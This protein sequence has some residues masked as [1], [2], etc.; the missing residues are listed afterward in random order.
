MTREFY[1]A[2]RIGRPKRHHP[3]FL[4]DHD[5]GRGVPKL[6]LDGKAAKAEAERTV[7]GSLVVVE[8]RETRKRKAFTER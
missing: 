7:S 5:S 2:V 6:W 3:Y 4:V 1:Y 8:V